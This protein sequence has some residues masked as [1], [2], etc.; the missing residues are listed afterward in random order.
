[1]RGGVLEATLYFD[2]LTTESSPTANTSN[3]HL[4]L[5]AYR[6][7]RDRL[8]LVTDCKPR[9]DVPDGPSVRVARR[10]GRAIQ[11]RTAVGL[12][13]DGKRLASASSAGPLRADVHR[14][15]GVQLAMWCGWRASGRIR[16]CDIGA[17]GQARGLN[18]LSRELA[19]HRCLH[20][21]PRRVGSPSGTTSASCTPVNRWNVRH[22]M[23]HCR[24]RSTPATCRP[25]SG[26]R[27]RV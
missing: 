25:A 1:M 24:R 22:A 3:A 8:A 12:M 18:S 5:L 23:V 19:V 27:R 7:R 2:E 9:P 4:L 17:P 20:R 13:P 11:K 10:R 26:R 14:L 21:R 15:T 6:S 16:R